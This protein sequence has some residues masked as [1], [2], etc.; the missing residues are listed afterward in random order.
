M[1]PTLLSRNSP[2][3]GGLVANNLVKVTVEE[4][5][6]ATI[7][8]CVGG[9]MTCQLTVGAEANALVRPSVD[10]ASMESRLVCYKRRNANPCLR[11]H[12]FCI[13][14]PHYQPGISNG[15]ASRKSLRPPIKIGG[16]VVRWRVSLASQSVIRPPTQGRWCVLLSLFGHSPFALEENLRNP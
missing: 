11:P 2:T 4:G 16:A 9:A 13:F 12:R 8:P 7:R 1:V 10:L 15:G 6:R 3:D 5:K 14:G